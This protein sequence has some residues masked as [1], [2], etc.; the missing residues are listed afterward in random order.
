MNKVQ[1][2]VLNIVGGVCGLL[3]VCDLVLGSLNGRL[4]QSALATQN[5]FNQAR[6]VQTTAQNLVMRVAQVGQSEPAL[7][8]LLAKHD[9][10]VNLNTNSQPRTTP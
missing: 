6:Q 9:F 3:I 1:F 5:Q 2:I 10:K 7:R 8:E 4:N